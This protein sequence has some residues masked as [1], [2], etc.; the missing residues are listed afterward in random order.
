MPRMLC[1]LAGTLHCAEGQLKVKNGPDLSE[2]IHSYACHILHS[3]SH[4]PVLV[5]YFSYA[6]CTVS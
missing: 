5:Y 1:T 4:W 6:W 3:V 2:H